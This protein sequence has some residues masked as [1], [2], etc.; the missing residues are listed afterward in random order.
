M[1]KITWADKTALNPQPS[2]ARENKVIDDDM[3]E[4]KSVVNTNDDSLIGVTNSVTGLM[5]TI[6]YDNSS[7]TAS[8]IPLSDNVNN[9]DYIEIYFKTNDTGS[10]ASRKIYNLW[11]GSNIADLDY[12]H[13]DGTLYYK[14]ANVSV[15]GTTITFL[16]NTQ[17]V[18]FSSRTTGSFIYITRVIG[19]KIESLN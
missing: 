5:G 10:I 6:L 17:Y 11:N 16:S 8:T 13:D 9:Y 15:N 18:N 7:G 12:G 3:N 2:I 1:A 14:S 4:I 19:Y